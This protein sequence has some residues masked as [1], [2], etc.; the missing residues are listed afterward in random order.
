MLYIAEMSPGIDDDVILAQANTNNALLLT[1]D[2]D[3]GELVF[4]QGLV[5]AGVVLIRLSGLHPA[6]KAQVV[7]SVLNE[8]STELLDAFSVIGPGSVR[9]RRRKANG[10]Q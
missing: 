8:H 1:L 6:T 3:F 2:K 10:L 7:A 9:I 4:R 5:H